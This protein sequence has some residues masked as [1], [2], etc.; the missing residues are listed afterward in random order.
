MFSWVIW[1]GLTQEKKKFLKK[2]EDKDKLQIGGEHDEALIET[3]KMDLWIT[4]FG[5]WMRKL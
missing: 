3:I 1:L 5:A 4:Y 2:Q